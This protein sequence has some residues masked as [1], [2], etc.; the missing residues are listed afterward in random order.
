MVDRDLSKMKGRIFRVAPKGHKMSVPHYDFTKIEG[1]VLALQSPNVATRY[2]AWE[3]LHELGPRA[4][5]ALVKLW[6][7][8]DQRMRAR[9]LHLLARIDGKAHKYVK[10]A[11][12]DKNADIRI[13]GL[14]I[15]RDLK[16]DVIPYVKKLADD[17]SSQVRRECALTLRGNTSDDAAKLWAELALQYDGKDRWYLEALGISAEKNEDGFF[18][19]WLKK[20]GEEW[21]TP[22]GR[23]II[24]R[25]RSSQAPAYLAR[26]IA[27]PGTPDSE[28]A[29]YFR[30]FDFLKG[31][32]KETALLELLGTA[33]GN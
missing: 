27:D 32:E 16:L 6:D 1:S 19:A 20:V 17:S 33:T 29:R 21:N 5:K 22:A 2:L 26:I 28:R 7:G 24:W 15:A 8:E 3:E 4:E 12:S 9:A 18:E 30:A 11:I 14:R 31:T 13:T 10:D 23:D 25:S